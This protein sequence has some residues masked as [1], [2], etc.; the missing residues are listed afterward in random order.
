MKTMAQKIKEAEEN[1]DLTRSE[2]QKVISKAKK[3]NKGKLIMFES[4]Y[5]AGTDEWGYRKVECHLF[6]G[7]NDER[8]ADVVI[9]CC[10]FDRRHSFVM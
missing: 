2:I 10:L 1:F 8:L 9:H 3:M 7:M 5:T 6:D 4:W